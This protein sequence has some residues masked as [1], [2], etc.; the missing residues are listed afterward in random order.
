MDHDQVTRTPS[1]MT[2][3][4]VSKVVGTGHTESQPVLPP[5]LRKTHGHGHSKH[6]IK[7]RFLDILEIFDD[8]RVKIVK[9][10]W[11]TQEDSLEDL[12]P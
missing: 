3:N 6:T 5:I 10:V 9:H 11:Q 1:P 12:H 2:E 8:T 7:P 4:I